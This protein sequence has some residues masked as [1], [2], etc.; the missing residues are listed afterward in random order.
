M[1]REIKFRAWDYI[2][3]KM[4]FPETENNSDTFFTGFNDGVAICINE[5]GA[6]YSLMQ[7]TG[8]KDKN[9]KEI[10]EGDIV[11]YSNFNGHIYRRVVVYFAPQFYLA[12]NL[13]EQF[14]LDTFSTPTIHETIIGNIYENPSLLQDS[15]KES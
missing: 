12:P 10:Y 14:N 6:N 15:T 5:D 2:S 9:G 1:T 7:F 3:K 4:F 8:L 13:S 11:E